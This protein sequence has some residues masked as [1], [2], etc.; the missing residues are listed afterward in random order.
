MNNFWE[1]IDYNKA[2]KVLV[3]PNITNSRNIEKDSFV[4]VIYNHIKALEKYGNYYWHILIPTG[5]I[6]K[7]LNLPNVKQYQID[8]PG[9]MLNQRAFPSPKLIDLL[10]DIDY[11]IIYSHLPDWP[12]VHRY[13]KTADTKIIGYCHWWEMKLCNG[14]DNRPGKP[15][16]LWF[17]MQ[18]LGASKMEVLY[19]NTHE[20]KRRV[21][22]EASETFNTAFISKLDNIIK[23][24]HLGV[25]EE[26]ILNKANTEKENIIVFNH[27][28]AGYKGYPK[29]MEMM[30]EYY[31]RRQDFVVW[32]TQL[33]GEVPH[34]WIKI[35][36]PLSKETYYQELQKCKVGI[37]MK[38]THYGWSIAATDCMMNGTP[39]IFQESPNYYELHPH[40]PFFKNKNEFFH[41]LDKMLD[42]NSFRRAEES[43]AL[44]RSKELFAEED[45]MI[46]ELHQRLGG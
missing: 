23:V 3:I 10:R 34:K 21:L 38:Q 22:E 9:D 6:T 12:Q 13:R 27:R 28:P 29:F 24:W 36:K 2:R 31:K 41:L 14:P 44:I 26:K 7:K 33:D 40:A 4:D 11:D 20:Q 16:S 32:V 18:I 8:I 45:I 19:V 15:K 37:Q 1:Q 39:V 25:P 35:I 43:K 17:Q 30:E 46:K 5:N 42:D